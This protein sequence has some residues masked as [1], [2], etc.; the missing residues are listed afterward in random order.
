[1]PRVDGFDGLRQRGKHVLQQLRL[2][3][4]DAQVGHQLLVFFVRGGSAAAA[5][6]GQRQRRSSIRTI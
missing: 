5:S 2:L 6:D 3:L 1:M 4:Q